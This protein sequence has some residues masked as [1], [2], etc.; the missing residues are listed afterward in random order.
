[1]PVSPAWPSQF[2]TETSTPL[3]LP[4]GA[5]N[6]R[7]RGRCAGCEMRAAGHCHRLP[8]ESGA[9]RHDAQQSRDDGRALAARTR[10]GDGHL[11]F[12]RRRRVARRATTT[13]AAK[14]DDVLAIAEWV[15]RVR[16]DDAL[17]L[18][19]IFVR[20]LR[21]R[22]RRAAVAGAADDF[23]RTADRA[24]GFQ[25]ARVAAVSVAGDPGRGRRDRRSAKRFTPGSPRSRNRRRWCACP[26]RDISSIAA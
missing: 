24:L 25:R 7:S 11:Q 14:R 12:P 6:D 9:G 20:R 15:Q 16:P 17:W 18:G 3:S 19:R 21:H 2:P 10:S 13:A 5:G 1:M 23:R 4:G 26:K 22:A 8:S